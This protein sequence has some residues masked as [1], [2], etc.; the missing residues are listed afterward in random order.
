MA[1]YVTITTPV[2][3][4]KQAVKRLGLSKSDQRFVECLFDPKCPKQPGVSAVKAGLADSVRAKSGN[5][6]ALT[7]ERKPRSRA[8][9]AA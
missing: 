4:W 1:H 8:R 3:T 7:V 2:P 9:K 6:G 5:K